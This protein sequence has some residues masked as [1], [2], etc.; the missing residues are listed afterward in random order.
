MA[1]RHAFYGTNQTFRSFF[2]FRPFYIG[3][4]R[5]PRSR[6]VER[7]TFQRTEIPNYDLL[8]FFSSFSARIFHFFIHKTNQHI[9][10][11][12]KTE[13]QIEKTYDYSY[14]NREHARGLRSVRS[15][16]FICKNC[17][18]KTKRNNYKL[19]RHCP[20]PVLNYLKLCVALC[21]YVGRSESSIH[22]SRFSSR[23]TE[24]VNKYSGFIIIA[25]ENNGPI[26]ALIRKG[27]DSMG[28]RRLF[29]P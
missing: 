24:Y 7:A 23:V 10:F 4:F 5:G 22:C 19:R 20:S 15:F 25:G 9:V 8:A 3:V 16:E 27:L 26:V 28:I 6:G 11:A 17:T 2:P 21:D 18:N 1:I 13:D 14:G 29:G 12:T